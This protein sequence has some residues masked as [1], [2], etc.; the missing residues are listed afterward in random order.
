MKGWKQIFHASG[1][2]KNISSYTSECI[3]T[4]PGGTRGKDKIDI[5]P[6]TERDKEGHSMMT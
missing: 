3:Y 6:Q 4:L 1:N 2:Q 5:Q